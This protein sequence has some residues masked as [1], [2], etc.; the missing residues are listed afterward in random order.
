MLC[1][2]EE[3][4]CQGL[5]GD[6]TSPFVSLL[7]CDIHVILHAIIRAP[8]LFSARVLRTCFQF[9][10]YK[11]DDVNHVGSNAVDAGTI[12]GGQEVLHSLR[13]PP[14]LKCLGQPLTAVGRPSYESSWWSPSWGYG[15]LRT[16]DYDPIPM[17]H[18]DIAVSPILC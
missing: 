13:S 4:R 18:V 7:P 12:G 9:G 6:S 10:R 11:K 8:T 16:G 17:T 5:R 3:C 14:G 1:P 15:L 2:F